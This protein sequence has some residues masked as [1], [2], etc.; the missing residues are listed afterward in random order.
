MALLRNAAPSRICA[1]L[2]GHDAEAG[3]PYLVKKSHSLQERNASSGASF[4]GTESSK[5][6]SVFS[7][8]VDF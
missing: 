4:D 7:A 2:V 1:E 6:T 8:S 3:Q 5:R